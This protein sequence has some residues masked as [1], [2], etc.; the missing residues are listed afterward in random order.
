MPLGNPLLNTMHLKQVSR[1]FLKDMIFL[2]IMGE[3]GIA[4]EPVKSN[5][6]NP[7]KDGGGGLYK[8]V[9]EEK[10][11]VGF[12]GKLER[13]REKRNR[14]GIKHKG[15]REQREQIPLYLLYNP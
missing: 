1:E 11:G 4:W 9:R 3:S 8:K 10:W 5:D 2:G 15:R 7:T 12:S 13:E 14:R 6:F